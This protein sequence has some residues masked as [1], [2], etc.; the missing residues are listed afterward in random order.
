MQPDYDKYI[1]SKR[2]V[3]A[4]LGFEPLPITAPLFPWQKQIVEW[5]VRKGRAALFEDCGLGKTAQQLEWAHQVCQHTGGSVLVLT[6]LA[7]AR[8]TQLEACK[9]GIPACVAKDQSDITGPGIWITNYERLD[10]FTP[11][12]FAGVVLDESSILKS[13]TGKI[14]QELTAAFSKTPYR[15]ACTATPSPNDYTELGQHA[16]FLGICTPAQMLA[17]YFINDTF[18]TGDWRLKK[19]AES[20]FWRWLASWAACVSKP[21][22]IGF[23]DD[24]YIL[25]KLNLETITV[26]VDESTETGEDLFRIATLSATTMHKE[27]RLTSGARADEVA[28]LVNHSDEPW[29]VW[30]NTNDEADALV[31]RIQGAIE[32]RGSDTPERKEKA[33]QWVKGEFCACG[34]K[35]FRAEF[36][37]WNPENTLGITTAKTEKRDLL[38]ARNTTHQTRK[39]ETNT[40][41]D[42]TK[43]TSTSGTSELQSSKQS[44]TKSAESDTNQTRR[45]ETQSK[46]ASKNGHPKIRCESVVSGCENTESLLS[47]TT[48]FLPIS[49]QDAQSVGICGADQRTQKDSSS[50][51]ATNPEPSEDCSATHAI[52]DSENSSTVQ[53]DLSRRQC[54]CGH[55]SGKRVLISKSSIFGFGLNFQACRNVAFVGLSYSF[56]DFYQALRRSYRFGQTREVNAYIVQA[57]TEGAILRAI[58]TKIE[59]HKTMQKN[60]KQA[61]K[62]L[63]FAKA[64]SIDAKV[65]ITTTSGDGWTVHH[66][67]CVRVA[68]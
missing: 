44:T 36:A 46:A 5:A 7:V 64:E 57:Q 26:S 21:S 39:S 20:A 52:L 18:N 68:R 38:K 54:I 17:T 16:D 42:I 12:E 27:M 2:K 58:E 65:D 9:F 60:M 6:P 61:A 11:E 32:V 31:E 53:S 59:Q 10:K 41:G 4:N 3:T 50:T 55:V 23:P 15:L 48:R 33:A 66:G 40:A 47:N 43:R 51:I 8:Q 1:A 37:A 25:P 45:I 13:L 49:N 30:C 28:R 14:R 62:E 67:D 24:G 29:I 19:H 34:D 22:D 63:R 56:E 35:C